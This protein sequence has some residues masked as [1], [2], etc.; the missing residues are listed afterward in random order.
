MRLPQE[1][2]FVTVLSQV[3]TGTAARRLLGYCT[4]AMRD[5]GDI[6]CGTPSGQHLW[7]LVSRLP[8]QRDAAQPRV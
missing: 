3:Q 4:Y 1:C 6:R 7:D 2:N 5:R 8:R